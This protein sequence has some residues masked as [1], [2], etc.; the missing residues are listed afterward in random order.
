MIA[1]ARALLVPTALVAV[2]FALTA[3][4]GYV[5]SHEPSR[6]QLLVQYEGTPALQPAYL[7]GSVV[8][9]EGGTLSIAT[10]S[11]GTR[12]VVV[13]RDTPIE[14]LKRSEAPPEAGARV[15]VGVDDTDFG[16]VLT[17]IVTIAETP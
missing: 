13:P 4:V 6:D 1:R 8:G 12:E 10:A 2:L 7:I 15:N 16:L 14:V 11:G 17:G 5:Y 3:I 9:L